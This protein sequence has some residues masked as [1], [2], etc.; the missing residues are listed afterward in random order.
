VYW[1]GPLLGGAFAG[2][3]YDFIFAED[4]SLKKLGRCAGC[5]DT[6]DSVD[7]QDNEER[8][9]SVLL[10]LPLLSTAAIKEDF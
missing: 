4:A 9:V 1:V 7:M 3:L 8:N 10:S 6:Y 2:L 5:S